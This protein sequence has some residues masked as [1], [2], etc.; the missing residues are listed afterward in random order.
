LK[1]TA[2][3]ATIF[4]IHKKNTGF[5]KQIWE[6]HSEKVE[7]PRFWK[8]SKKI[9]AVWSKFGIFIAKKVEYSRFEIR[10]NFNHLIKWNSDLE[11]EKRSNVQDFENHQKSYAKHTHFR[12]FSD[13]T[14]AQ[15]V[16]ILK[17]FNLQQ[18][19]RHF[20][21]NWIFPRYPAVIFKFLKFV[22]KTHTW[23]SW[24]WLQTGQKCPIFKIIQDPTK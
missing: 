16:Q 3:A 22:R 7:H 9:Q 4:E 6:F 17:L 24:F 23:S 5:I 13:Y 8:S 15:N 10:E 19:W 12:A 2:G 11:T 21:K 1:T 20:E 14:Q 18:K